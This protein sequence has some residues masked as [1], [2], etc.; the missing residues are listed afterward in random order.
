MFSFLLFHPLFLLSCLLLLARVCVCVCPSHFLP[1]SFPFIHLSSLLSLSLLSRH[2]PRVC[3]CVLSLAPGLVVADC[4]PRPPLPLFVRDGID[5]FHAVWMLPPSLLAQVFCYPVTFWGRL[6]DS[7]NTHK[8]FTSFVRFSFYFRSRSSIVFFFFSS[9]NF[10]FFFFVFFYTRH[11]THTMCGDELSSSS[12]SKLI[13]I[14][15]VSSIQP[16][17]QEKRSCL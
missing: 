9:T 14:V 1:S 7:C 8:D 12:S 5:R 4:R 10:K 6:F 17:Q 13:A 11:D 15:S 2:P 3:V 16:E